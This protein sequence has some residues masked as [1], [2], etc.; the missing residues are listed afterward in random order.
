MPSVSGEALGE[1][2]VAVDCSGS[3]GR[4]E[5]NEFSAEIKA[6]H[7]DGRPAA[8][9]VVYF[10]SKVCH[11]DRFDADDTVTISAKGGGG[12]AFSPVFRYLSANN[13]EPVA[14]VFLTDLE[15]SD[16]GP[17]PDH[18]VLWVSNG[19]TRAPWGEVVKL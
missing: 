5:L 17:R 1:I 6:L 14:T 18:P 3:I 10:D 9:H 2:V 8:L 12:T 19:A 4:R 11:Y 7:E 15:C 13:I 16:F